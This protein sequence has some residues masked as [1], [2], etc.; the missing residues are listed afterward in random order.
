MLTYSLSCYSTFYPFPAAISQQRGQA[1]NSIKCNIGLLQGRC[2][3][4]HLD[5][6]QTFYPL[7]VRFSKLCCWCSQPLSKAGN[8]V[9]ATESSQ[10]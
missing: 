6:P 9:R 2:P 10:L 5:P 4:D 1:L 8:R 3:V 7:S